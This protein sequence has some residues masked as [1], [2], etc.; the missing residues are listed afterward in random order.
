MATAPGGAATQNTNPFTKTAK[1]HPAYCKAPTNRK[2]PPTPNGPVLQSSIAAKQYHAAKN[3]AANHPHY[4][5]RYLCIVRSRD[6]AYFWE[7]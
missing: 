7:I 5:T 2:A 1:Q 4:S 3:H 6:T